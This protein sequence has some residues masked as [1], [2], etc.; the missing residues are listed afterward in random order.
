MWVRVLVILFC[1][2]LGAGL[3]FLVG[4]KIVSIGGSGAVGSAFRTGLIPVAVFLL[5]LPV[6]AMH[7]LLRSIAGTS[8]LMGGAC[9]MLFLIG[10][11]IGLWRESVTYRGPFV[12]D[13]TI[14]FNR[15]PKKLFSV[16]LVLGLLGFA[17]LFAA[18]A[19]ALILED[20]TDLSLSSPSVEPA[21]QAFISCYRVPGA[22]S[23]AVA[24]AG[25]ALSLGWD[26]T[27]GRALEAI[28]T[29]SARRSPEKRL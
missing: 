11:V 16:F 29:A 19:A 14:A 20:L 1:L 28:L 12:L 7:G 5:L 15:F 22:V 3:C 9:V 4:R 26:W 2:A 10:L 24:A 6:L 25:L 23:F 21:V 13:P 27:V 18:Q 17:P 8:I